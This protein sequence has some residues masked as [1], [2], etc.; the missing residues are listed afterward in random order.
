MRRRLLSLMIFILLLVVSFTVESSSLWSDEA[1][2]LYQGE[3]PA[4]E[5]GDIVTVIIEENID[6]F[7]SANTST[8]QDSSVDS[9]PG[10]GIF[11]FLKVFGFRYSDSDG[12]EGATSRTGQVQGDI[13]TLITEIYPNGNFMIEGIKK[14]KVDGEEQTIRLSG[15]IR[16]DDIEEDNSINS[17]KV[18]DA[19][20][21]FEGQ[22][23]IAD[24]QKPNVFQRILNWLF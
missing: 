8:S 17:K 13:T 11:D 20:I 7:Q 19:S 24:K 6:A 9:S 3:K 12:S 5:I 2:G 18:A 15:I 4:Y 16:P 22:G 10:L 23:V 14:V 1:A 21:E